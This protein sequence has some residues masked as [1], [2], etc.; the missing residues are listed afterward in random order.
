MIEIIVVWITVAILGITLAAPLGPVNVEMIKQGLNKSISH[1][2]AWIAA[3]L[4]GVGAMNGDFIVATTALTVGGEILIDVFSSPLIRLCLFTIN[5]IIL[6]YLGISALI[7]NP[8]LQINFSDEQ[9][10]KSD[11]QEMQINHFFFIRRYITGLSLVISSPWSYLWWVSA[12]T[13]ILFSDFNVPDF[14]SRIALVIMFLSGI[15]LWVI[16]FCTLLAIIGKSPDPK[17]FKWITK[18]SAIILL[19]FA[20]IIVQDAWESFLELLKQI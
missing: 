13:I 17:K 14:F 19:L 11:E 8:E 1:K 12:G 4:T 15:L 7:Q 20:G 5:I 3:I 6:G 9:K 18:G 2:S 16:S 10:P